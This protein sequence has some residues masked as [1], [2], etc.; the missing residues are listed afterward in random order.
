MTQASASTLPPSEHSSLPADARKLRRWGLRLLALALLLGSGSYFLFHLWDNLHAL[1]PI[2]WGWSSTG[3]I[4]LAA[5]GCLTTVPLIALMWQWLL[6]DQGVHLPYRQALQIIAV[7]QM[8]KYLPG[9]VGHFAGRVLLG[10]QAGVPAGKTIATMAMETFWVLGISALF[11]FAALLFYVSELHE[12][13]VDTSHPGY[14][15]GVALLMLVAP[16]F[17][18]RLVNRLLPGLSRKLGRGHLLAEPRAITAIGVA[19]LITLSFVVLGAVVELLASHLFQHPE[20]DLVEMIL[21]FAVSW[22]AG[23]LVPGSPGGLGVREA[24]MI[25][26]MGPVI[27][28]ETALGVAL[29]MRL[30][31]MGA[32]ALAFGAGLLARPVPSLR[33]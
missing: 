17:G 27:G 7:S 23:F 30:C 13:L 14:L 32:D 9:N 20:I 24:V 16:F 29:V 25:Q 15:G 18:V 31:S 4:A 28:L 1:P 33:D 2:T 26:L 10:S 6:R 11:A 19:G 22:T 5:L 3:V 12:G 8:G 21:L